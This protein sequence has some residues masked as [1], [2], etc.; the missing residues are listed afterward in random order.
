MENQQSDVWKKYQIKRYFQNRNSTLTY[1]QWFVLKSWTLMILVGIVV[2]CFGVAL[3]SLTRE[4]LVWKFDTAIKFID[5]NDWGSA[6]FSYFFLSIFF[7]V[8]STS[9]CYWEPKG[10]DTRNHY[11]FFL[12]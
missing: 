9:F 8:I 5:N 10:R 4:L 12:F 2:G 6:F 3:I 11:Y 7:V 1:N